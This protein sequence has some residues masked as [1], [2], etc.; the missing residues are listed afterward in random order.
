MKPRERERERGSTQMHSFSAESHHTAYAS[1]PIL[2]A[3]FDYEKHL[4][5]TP[6]V[7]LGKFP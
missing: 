6:E 1:I 3:D 5:I 4:A 2:T 7:I